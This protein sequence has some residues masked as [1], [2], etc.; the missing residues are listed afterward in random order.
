MS[1][2]SEV[3]Q[4]GSR[5]AVAEVHQGGL[6][7]E[8]LRHHGLHIRRLHGVHRS[9]GSRAVHRELCRGQA[10]HQ[11]PLGARPG[12]HAGPQLQLGGRL[13]GVQVGIREPTELLQRA[14]HRAQLRSRGT[15]SGDPQQPGLLVEVVE[16]L[17]LGVGEGVPQHRGGGQ[18]QSGGHDLRGGPLREVVHPGSL[19][20]V[21]G[22]GLVDV[23]ELVVVLRGALLHLV[24]LPADV[25]AGHGRDSA[26]LRVRPGQPD[27]VLQGVQEVVVIYVG[28]HH[29]DVLHA[30]VRVPAVPQRAGLEVLQV[31]RGAIHAVAQRG[32]LE[33]R[34]VG[35]VQQPGPRGVPLGLLHLQPHQPLA[36]LHR[37]VGEPGEKQALPELVRHRGLS[38][39]VTEALDGVGE[40]ALADQLGGLH[41]QPGLLQDGLRD[42]LGGGQ[43][44]LA[45]R[46]F[47]ELRGPGTEQRLVHRP[48]LVQEAQPGN[49]APV[50][51]ANNPNAI[52]QHS[53]VQLGVNMV[54]AG[55]RFPVGEPDF[56]CR[57]K[58]HS[59]RV[60][61][62]QRRMAAI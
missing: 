4:H 25:G 41:L 34:L 50:V 27:A 42:E 57:G 39:R 49:A 9:D 29:G 61:F 44:V 48:V 40:P 16:H 3:R 60:T 62:A 8:H 14:L 23:H 10:V 37:G 59:L 18:L 32:A 33:S 53:G 56:V 20:G 30:V 54:R 45:Q 22:E 6:A 1:F 7:A 11:Q 17:D 24:A 58:L 47:H 12:V 51:L 2:R 38:H 52:V 31:V 15:G 21:R 13:V 5:G 43:T 28:R 19:K 55:H 26:L 46:V 36:L 35:Q